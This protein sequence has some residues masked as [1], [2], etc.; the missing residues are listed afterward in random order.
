MGIRKQPT[1][2]HNDAVERIMQFYR[3]HPNAPKWSGKRRRFHEARAN[4]FFVGLLLD[5]LQTAERAWEGAS[6][7]V[8][9]YFTA[10]GNFWQ[11]ISET[12][13]ATVRSICIR[14][15]DEQPFALG[16]NVNSFPRQLRAAAKK[17]VDE[18]DSDVRKIWNNVSK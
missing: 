15:F 18:Y 6:Y 9:N 12:H 4:K 8:D 7:L 2:A 14:G 10:S 17:I 5:Q 1:A 3:G 11:E 16:M 13:H